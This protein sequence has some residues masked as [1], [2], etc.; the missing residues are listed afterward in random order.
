MSPVLLVRLLSFALATSP[1]AGVDPL[2]HLLLTGGALGFLGLTEAIVKPGLQAPANCRLLGQFCDP[3]PLWAGDRAVLGQQSRAW[4]QIS[5]GLQ[6]GSLLLPVAAL[7]GGAAL[8]VPS[9]GFWAEFGPDLLV[10]GE[11]VSLANLAAHGLKYAVRRPRPELYRRSLTRSEQQMSFPSGHSTSVAAAAAAYATLFNLR[12]PS[13]PWRGPVW[14]AAGLAV[15]LT[16]SG[17]VLGGKHFT[18]DVLAGA[19]IGGVIGSLVPLLHRARPELRLQV[20]HLPASVAT[21][22][23]GSW[24]LTAMSSVGGPG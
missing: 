22:P 13:S 20:E 21:G 5:D 4:R 10:W 1:V 7:A 6:W 19:L 24:W 2:P 8:A 14:G 16:A 9:A 18:S 12:Y 3:A 11:A 23:A 15:G 17:R